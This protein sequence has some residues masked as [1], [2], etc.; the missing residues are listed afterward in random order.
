MVIYFFIFIIFFA[1]SY[2]SGTKQQQAAP[3]K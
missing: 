2:N 1:K 3:D